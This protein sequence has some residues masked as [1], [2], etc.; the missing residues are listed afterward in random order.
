MGSEGNSRI[1][2]LEFRESHR[3]DQLEVLETSRRDV[4]KRI[5]KLILSALEV[6][7]AERL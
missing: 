5:R 2:P 3:A 6:K 1:F 7:K 4:D